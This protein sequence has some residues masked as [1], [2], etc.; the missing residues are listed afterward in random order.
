M[1]SM[2][3]HIAYSLVIQCL[4]QYGGDMLNG[5]KH[6]PQNPI[7]LWV[8]QVCSVCDGQVKTEDISVCGKT[9]RAIC[10]TCVDTGECTDESNKEIYHPD[11]LKKCSKCELKTSTCI[12]NVCLKCREEAL[13]M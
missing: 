7:E 4:T 1:A 12:R 13:T 11:T 8:G 3:Y 2:R 9:H 10:P 6:G 5:G